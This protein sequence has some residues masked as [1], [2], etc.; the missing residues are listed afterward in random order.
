MPR[1]AQTS[2][3]PALLGGDEIWT[4]NINAFSNNYAYS[5]DALGILTGMQSATSP[6]LPRWNGDYQALRVCNTFLDNI[7]SVPDMPPWER[8]QWIAEVKV[9]KAYYH[10]L[11]IRMYGPVPLIRESNPV[12]SDFSKLKRVREPVDDCFQ[13]IVELLDQACDG[14]MLPTI[15]YDQASELGRIT[16][17]IAKSL[18]AKI[19]V[20]AASPLFNGNNDQATLLN[21]DN[22]PLFNA[23]EEPAKW[24]RAMIACKE[25]IDVCHDAD[26]M[27]YV[28]P[29]I[30]YTDAIA[31]DVT[32]RNAFSERWNS[33][34]I[35]ANTQSLADCSVRGMIRGTMP[36]LTSTYA[37]QS[38]PKFFGI[39]LKTA[40]MFYT[41]H[42]VPLEEDKTRDMSKIYELRTA[43]TEDNLY[44]REGRISI[45]LHFDREPR[46]YA[47]VGFDGGVW[48][49]AD[50]FN[51]QI[52]SSL[53][54][55]GFKL[56]EIDG[57]T[58]SGPW[59]GYIPKK[60]IPVNAQVIG[61]GSVSAIDYPWPIMRLSDLY[62]LYAEAI[63]EA[64]G[65]RGANSG[66][67]FEYIDSVRWRAGL[68]GVKESWGLYSTNSQKYAT[69]E[70]MRE[71]IQQ[72]RMI[73]LSF[74]GQ[75]FWDVRRWKIASDIYSKPLEGW[76][77]KVSTIDGTDS[78]IN[79]IMY[80]PQFLMQ[81]TFGVKDYFWP[82]RSSDIDVNP[83]LVQNI[84][85]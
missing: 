13:Y 82:I 53:R 54:W 30:R 32:L 25:A 11:L 61:L 31:T 23:T 74:E 48:F 29:N 85:W 14:D 45:D 66:E 43:Q 34:I 4:V 39:P 83:N 20:T 38:M 9:L 22:T 72:E 46:F 60:H 57:S 79:R 70:G 18:K 63:N 41:H 62:L 51:D 24:Q 5:P 77:M 69:Q 52:P 10:F 75:R 49:G 42:G 3:N 58:G 19:L 50:Q 35:W 27:L 37:S 8:D 21:R 7:G 17:P 15:I 65:P 64:E 81:P 2:G 26:I 59:T 12:K 36:N 71:I 28:F 76:N 6:I 44:I 55:L 67:M 1:D 78:Q 40:S 33:E 84:G 68:K 47:W 16:K 56:G 80:T 73:E